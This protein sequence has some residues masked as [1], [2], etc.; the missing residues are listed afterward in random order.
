[1][2]ILTF[3]SHYDQH[4]HLPKYLPFV[5]NHLVCNAVFRGNSE[6]TLLTMNLVWTAKNFKTFLNA[7]GRDN[8]RRYSDS[9]RAAPSGDQIPVGARFPAPVQTGP[10]ANST[11]YTMGTLS[12]QGVKR[13][14]HGTD[15]PPYL[16]PRLKKEYRYASTPFWAFVVCSRVKF[17][18]YLT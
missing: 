9:L 4:H 1:M 7:W 10:G 11:S 14:K 2:W 16:E 12:F 15:H 3:F 5:L 18:F 8:S 17:T 13:P 6:L